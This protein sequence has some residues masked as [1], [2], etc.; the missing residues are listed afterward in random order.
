MSRLNLTWRIAAAAGVAVI[1][2]V[3]ASIY[4]LL[5]LT[6]TSAKYDALLSQNEVQHQ[7]RARVMQVTFKKQVQEWKNLLLRG[8]KYEDFKKYQESFKTEE[9]LVRKQA[10]ELAK[11]VKDAD[12]KQQID[13]FI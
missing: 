10:T 5:T 2:G 8:E 7:D 12:A 13:G 3:A 1:T 11:D 6:S 4:L 9:A